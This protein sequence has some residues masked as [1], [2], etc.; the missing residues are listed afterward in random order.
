MREKKALQT[1]R[2]T[3]RRQECKMTPKLQKRQSNT[4]THLPLV[5]L[6][7]A[8]VHAERRE[9]V[10]HLGQLK[11]YQVRL[12]AQFPGFLHLPKEKAARIV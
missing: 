5:E 8:V 3:L 1:R 6:E 11:R 2:N 4:P 10:V 9:A 12:L 7:G